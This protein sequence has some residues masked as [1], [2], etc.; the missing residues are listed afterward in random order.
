MPI[1]LLLGFAFRA[2]IRVV[3]ALVVRTDMSNDTARM[4]CTSHLDP[5]EK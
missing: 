4:V 5:I 2:Q 1:M 3:I